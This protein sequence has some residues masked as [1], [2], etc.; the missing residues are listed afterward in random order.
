MTVMTTLAVSCHT[1]GIW[2]MRAPQWTLTRP[3][4]MPDSQAWQ[5]THIPQQPITQSLPH[6]SKFPEQRSLSR[7]HFSRCPSPLL[8]HHLPTGWDCWIW[9]SSFAKTSYAW[10]WICCH[11]ELLLLLPVSLVLQSLSKYLKFICSKT[12]LPFF[13]SSPLFTYYVIASVFPNLPYSLLPVLQACRRSFILFL[14]SFNQLMLPASLKY[15]IKH[16]FFFLLLFSLI[17]LLTFLQSR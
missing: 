5:V 11:C 14:R 2:A 7:R 15:L 3:A 12:L 6:P 8:P 17:F 4:V 13:I 9:H 16:F 1:V 10:Q